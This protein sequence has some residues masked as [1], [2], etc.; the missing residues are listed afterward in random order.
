MNT[1]VRPEKVLAIPFCMPIGLDLGE[2]DSDGDYNENNVS[3]G[4]KL[5]GLFKLQNGDY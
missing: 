5:D 1:S 4:S 2:M 3:E